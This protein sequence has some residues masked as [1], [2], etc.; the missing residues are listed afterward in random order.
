VTVES[1]WAEWRA[2]SHEIVLAKRHMAIECGITSSVLDGDIYRLIV[3]VNGL[4][5]FVFIKA[6]GFLSLR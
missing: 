4:I 2:L 3:S 5:Y 6:L 1:L